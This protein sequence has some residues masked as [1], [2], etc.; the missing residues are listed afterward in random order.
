MKYIKELRNGIENVIRSHNAFIIGEDVQD[1]Y[2]GAFKVT[3]GLSSLYPNNIIAVPMCEQ[4]F[5][6]MGVGMAVEGSHVVVES[7]FGDFI[8]LMADQMINHAAKFYQMYKEP[9][10][11]VLRCP[12]GG[13]RG[14]GAT[15]SQS[16]ER[17]YF[18]IP[19]VQIVAPSIAHN[20][21]GLLEKA[22]DSGMPTLFV[23]N[24]SDYPRELLGSCG[25]F[26]EKEMFEEEGF[27]IARIKV[28]DE[29]PD[30][31]IL[32]YGGLVQD[33]LD[34]MEY[35]LYEEEINI[36]IV[37]PSQISG[38][39]NVVDFVRS[40]KVLII[41]E[42]VRDFGWSAEIACHFLGSGVK[43]QRA[44]A[45]NSFIPASNKW[46]YK[47]LLQKEDMIQMI[48]KGME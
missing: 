3:K 47:V 19:G 31:T 39:R 13:Y 12:S 24:K 34:V 27:P 33:A 38:T 41:E 1:P 29:E 37:V 28:K 25:T 9:V 48:Q 18:G 44:G 21:G 17:I 10:R 43:V 16:L 22:L 36:D 6:G 11:I 15:H 14:Y 4:G 23:E 26:W 7:M 40:R 42:G 30:Y 20:P 8:T 5:F 45:E 2:G 35:F 32:T 46:E